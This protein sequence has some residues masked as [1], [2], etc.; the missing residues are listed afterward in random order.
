[1]ITCVDWLLRIGNETHFKNSSSKNIWGINSK[2]SYG[3]SFIKN[4][5]PGD[6]LWFVKGKSNGKIV[7]VVTYVKVVERILGPL[8]PLT[9]TNSELGWTESKGEWD[10]EVRYE[11]LYNLTDCNLNS[12]I[13]GA[14]GIRKY[15]D[16]CKVNLSE[17]YPHIIRYSKVTKSM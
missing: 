17:V 15:N 3:K 7:A 11:N 4:A 5:K 1:M 12:E 13:K 9:K 16:K 2:T 8:I 14:C 6:R 10:T